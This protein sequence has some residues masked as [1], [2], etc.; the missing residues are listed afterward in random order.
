MHICPEC[1]ADVDDE[2]FF[3]DQCGFQLKL[4]NAAPASLLEPV[5]QATPPLEAA[6][7]PVS[8]ARSC[9]TCGADNP[10]AE[11]Y[12]HNCGFWLMAKVQPTDAPVGQELRQTFVQ[13]YDS[14]PDQPL[15]APSIQPI[16]RVIASPYETLPSIAITGRLFSPSSKATL[17]LPAKA[18]LIIGRR[19]PERGIYPDIDLGDQ[20]TVSSSVSRQHARLLVQDKQIYIEDLNSTNSTFVNRHRLQPGQRYLLNDGDEIRL[21]GVALVYYSK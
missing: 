21:G 4:K 9:P 10:A 16:P 7:P 14:L 12:C 11:T 13:P 15:V 18:E 3:C 6:I 17:P 1:H 5:P 2:A 19:D 8:S 20:G